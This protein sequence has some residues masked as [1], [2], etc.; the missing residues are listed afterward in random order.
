MIKNLTG[1]KYGRLMVVGF[2]HC[3][4][5]RTSH[6]KCKCDCGGE[7]IVRGNLLQQR[8]T[9]S[10]GCL[11]R[12]VMRGRNRAEHTGWKGYGEISGKL[13]YTIKKGCHRKSRMLSFDVSIKY[14]WEV[15]LN[16]KRRCALSGIP[17]TFRTRETI[18]DGT[19]SL[20]RIDSSLGYVEGNV[21]W[22]H[23]DINA[24]KRDYTQKYFVDMCKQVA[25][26]SK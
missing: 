14:L 9:Q 19:A 6:W 7:S 5:H 8:K 16:Q 20:D 18:Y 12:E 2:S 10:C 25:T 1:N 21:Q 15:F 17:L 13:F 3:D 22:V 26:Q 4:T 11:H 23:K 24:M